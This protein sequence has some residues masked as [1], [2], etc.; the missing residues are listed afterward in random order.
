MDVVFEELVRTPS[1]T[2]S[3]GTILNVR[4]TA[5]RAKYRDVFCNLSRLDQM[6]FRP[7]GT[8]LPRFSDTIFEYIRAR[9]KTRPD[10]VPKLHGLA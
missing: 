3:S 10:P 8:F 9:Q 4:R 7:T 2:K 1:S 6:Q 5:R